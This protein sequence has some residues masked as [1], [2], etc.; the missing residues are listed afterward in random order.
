M[1]EHIK[2]FERRAKRVSGD[3]VVAVPNLMSRI[4]HDGIP[5]RLDFND[6]GICASGVDYMVFPSRYGSA[7]PK[8][9]HSYRL[10]RIGRETSR[11]EVHFGALDTQDDRV[12]NVAVKDSHVSLALG[13]LAMNQYVE[14]LGLPVYEHIGMVVC[15]ESIDGA[16]DRLTHLLSIFNPAVIS[17]DNHEW[18][19]MPEYELKDL[20]G[21]AAS[22][23]GNL[24]GKGIRHGD[25]ELKNFGQNDAGNTFLVDFEH[26]H[27]FKDIAIIATSDMFDTQTKAIAQ[28][29]VNKY[30]RG[31][32]RDVFNSIKPFLT[33]RG[34]GIGA[35]YKLFHKAFFGAYEAAAVGEPCG[36]S[37]EAA[38]H[39]A[40]SVLKAESKS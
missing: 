36:S 8:N 22:A 9:F 23:L 24:N 17:M 33:M 11:H 28:D 14:H 6:I 13:E 34:K 21:Y 1:S 40:H 5:T 29:R 10:Q 39:V 38:M 26:A 20:L 31:D 7:I 4:R 35:A 30:V 37:V 16:D 12:L 3:R 27:S 19:G 32:I 15:A 2:E 25:S 18:E